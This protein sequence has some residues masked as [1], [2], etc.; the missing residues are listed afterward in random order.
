[1]FLPVALLVAWVSSVGTDTDQFVRELR[2]V[3]SSPQ[4]REAL[5]DRVIAGVQ[6]QLDVP[7]RVAQQLEPPLRE[8]VGALGSIPRDKP[9]VTVCR[10]GGRSAQAFVLL[11]RAGVERVANLTGGMLRWHENGLP[12]SEKAIG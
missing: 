10:S 6:A 4:V 8:L 11:K 1:M 12:V 5:T 2:P 9:I 3:A 7:D